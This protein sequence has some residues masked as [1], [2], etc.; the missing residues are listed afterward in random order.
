MAEASFSAYVF[1]F[2]KGKSS[3][4]GPF[5]AKEAKREGRNTIKVVRAFLAERCTSS[6]VKSKHLPKR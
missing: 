1:G 4:F 6:P 5:E 3:F 2:L